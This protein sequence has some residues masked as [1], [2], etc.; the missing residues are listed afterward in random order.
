MDDFSALVIYHVDF[1]GNIP[2]YVA[3]VKPNKKKEEE[4]KGPHKSNL[5]GAG[6]IQ[7]MF[8]LDLYKIAHQVNQLEL[9][10]NG[11]PK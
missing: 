4:E 8:E 3:P 6:F 2:T 5:N 1:H 7:C 9:D 11:R 10:H